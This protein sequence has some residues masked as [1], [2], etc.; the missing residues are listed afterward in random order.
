MY[1]Q[2]LYEVADPVATITLNRPQK[3]N[4]WTPKMGD[5]VKHAL[6]Q[7]EADARVVVIILT[8]A[9]R[10]FCS[11]ADLSTLSTIASGENVALTSDGTL[12]ADPGDASIGPS[13]RGTYSYFPSIRKP[14]IAAIN[15]PCAGMAVPI[16]LFCD[17]RF[18]SDRA[19]FLTAFVR[20]GLIAEWGV[21]WILP[22]LVGP[23]RALDLLLSSR[24]LSAVEAFEMGLVNR[25]VPH[26]ELLDAARAYATELAT[27]C[28]PTA[29]S[30]I[31]REIYQHMTETHAHAENEA[32]QLMLQS[33]QRPD[34]RE[35]VAAVLE[36][37]APR[38]ER[39]GAAAKAQ[40]SR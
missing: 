7:A 18:A 40:G 16:S 23:A 8:G 32:M 14:I 34:F 33:F 26:D 12:D 30:I 25:V 1:E 13:F 10:G 38:F 29:M 9:G 17:L 36:K 6:A 15:G 4:A 2:I 21:S 5:E 28:S 11:G 37:R 27:H 31:K 24:T 39:L 22:K 19:T 35:G 20:R 3:L